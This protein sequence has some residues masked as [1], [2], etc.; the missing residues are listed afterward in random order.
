M[1]PALADGSL[2]PCPGVLDTLRAQLARL[3][4]RAGEVAQARQTLQRAIVA[5]EQ[6][7]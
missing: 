1:L 6:A 4:Q 5:T 2:R 3:D 7:D